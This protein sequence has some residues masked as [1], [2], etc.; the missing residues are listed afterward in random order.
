MD[1]IRKYEGV[2]PN[3]AKKKS[4]I[5]MPNMIKQG[6]KSG[7]K[8]STQSFNKMLDSTRRLLKEFYEPFN[9]LLAKLLNERLYLKWNER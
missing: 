2:M 3:K 9:I 5:Q 8:N 7:R 6:A 1:D 4:A